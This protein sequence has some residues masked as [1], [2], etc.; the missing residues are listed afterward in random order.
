MR[1][2][3]LSVCIITFNEEA[4]IRRCL[5]SVSWADDIVVVD[6]FSSDRTPEIAGEFTDKVFKAPWKGYVVQKNLAISYA[7]SD[8][9]L[10]IDADEVVSGELRRSIE[11]VLK[12]DDRYNG[13]YIPRR[14]FY[15][16]RW[17]NHCG[18]YPDYKLRLFRR[19]HGRWVGGDLHERIS[20]DGPAG[21]LEGD[22]YHFPYADISAHL[23]TINEYSTIMANEFRRRG[24]HPRWADLFFRPLFRFLKMY[25]LKLG[26]MDGM[27]GL[28]VSSLGAIYVFCKYAKLW[29][30]HLRSG[31]RP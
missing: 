9:I 23:R 21:Y 13:Y 12:G 31:G 18:W 2:G 27:A 30:T 8:W 4:N 28:L 25:F 5:E 10:A 3:T 11:R 7:S 15:L 20:L 6:S 22:L 1:T 17:I 14:V 29:E 16:G 24:R 19:G 26:F